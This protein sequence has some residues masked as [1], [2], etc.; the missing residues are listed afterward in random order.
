MISEIHVRKI[1]EVETGGRPTPI[2][3][4]IKLRM[5]IDN[6]GFEYAGNDILHSGNTDVNELLKF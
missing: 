1:K 2:D 3:N 6:V 4:P 5:A